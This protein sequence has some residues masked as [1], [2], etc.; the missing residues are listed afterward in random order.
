MFQLAGVKVSSDVLTVP[1]VASL[2]LT[3][4]LTL[5]VGAVSSATVNDALPPASVVTRPAPGVATAAG[6][7]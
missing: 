2:L 5:A 1:S 4:K 7:V 3:A 6:P